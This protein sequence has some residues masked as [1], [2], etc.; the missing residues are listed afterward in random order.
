MLFICCMGSEIIIEIPI[1]PFLKDYLVHLF[2]PEPVFA[3]A[4]SV[5]F[6]II[7]PM[8]ET[9]PRDQNVLPAS[10]DSSI[11]INLPI[12]NKIFNKNPLSYYYISDSNVRNFQK[13][14]HWWFHQDFFH[15]MESRLSLKSKIEQLDN[16]V[17]IDIAKSNFGIFQSI[18]EFCELRDLHPD[19]VD[20][21]ALKKAFFRHR[22]VFFSKN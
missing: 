19:H 22:E 2:G 11:R 18:D 1:K 20:V 5:L 10:F 16:E 9:A 7:Y 3:S 13:I 15:F 14:I 6:P 21:D 12:Q 4:T 8:L 17:L